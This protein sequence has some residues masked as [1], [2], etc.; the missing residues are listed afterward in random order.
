MRD[1]DI[2]AEDEV[3]KAAG[4]PL[5]SFTHVGRTRAQSTCSLALWV[6]HLFQP[7]PGRN[8][9]RQVLMAYTFFAHYLLSVV[10]YCALA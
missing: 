10:G 7:Q 1:Y 5:P 6:R 3:P 9:M 4:T 8:C 2:M